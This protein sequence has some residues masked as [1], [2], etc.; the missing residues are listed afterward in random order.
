MRVRNE[1]VVQAWLS[2]RRACNHMGTL[3][4]DGMRLWSYRLEIGRR[5]VHGRTSQAVVGDFT[6]SGGH[7]ASQ[8]TSCH[9]SLAKRKRGIKVWNPQVYQASFGLAPDD[10][11]KRTEENDGR[12]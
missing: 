4:T 1:E 10:Y 3:E 5:G 11:W 9:V 2:G 7:F 8:T 12:S 6:A